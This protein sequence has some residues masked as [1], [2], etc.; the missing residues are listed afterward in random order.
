MTLAAQ[1]PLTL[2]QPP[3]V[4]FGVGALATCAAALLQTGRRHVALVTSPSVA[5]AA[6]GLAAPLRDGGITVTLVGRVPAEPDVAACE[7]LRAELQPHAI[8][9]VVGLGGGSVLDVAKLLAALHGR[10][11]PVTRY[12]GSGLLPPRNVGLICLPTTA[13]TGSEVSPNA[14]LY[15]ETEALKKAV[16][17]PHL[18]PDAAYIDPQLTV[19][20]SPAL[21]AATGVDALVHCIEAYGNRFAH[22]IV[23]GYALQGIRLIA[24]HLRRAVTAGSDLE[25]RSAVALGSLYG[26]LCLGPVNTAAVHALAYPLGS[27]FR[28]AH[29]LS[30]ALLLPHVLRFN[31]SAAPERYADIARAAGV[32]GSG[33]AA[34]IAARGVEQLAALGREC[35]IPAGLA[36]VGVP[37]D[38]VPR[39][40]KAALKVTRLLKNN[41]R[42][43]S[44]ADA[45]QIYRQAM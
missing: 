9:A 39:L 14:I 20:A 8:D 13:G 42:E 23:D 33:S 26:G 34:E 37:A 25:A 38:A 41:P 11:E 44:L 7:R 17:S 16:I 21:T 12:F 18:V 15:D 30:N 19:S 28:L 4:V 3:T 5:S 32:T 1:R 31:L 24:A 45:E 10:T 29:G 43:I 27:E 36:A 2:L 40:A 22:P 35:G 6:E